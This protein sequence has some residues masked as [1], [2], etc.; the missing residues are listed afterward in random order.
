MLFR[1][2]GARTL[3]V[4]IQQFIAE[5]LIRWDLI[6]ASGVMAAIPIL[7]GFMFAQRVLISGL[8]AGAVKG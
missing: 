1:S 8:T 5:D 7:I 4:G 6:T 3:P 2:Q